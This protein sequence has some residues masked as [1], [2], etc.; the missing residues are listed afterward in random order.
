MAENSK[1][2]A[3]ALFSWNSTRIKGVYTLI[4]LDKI[5][6]NNLEILDAICIFMETMAEVKY[7]R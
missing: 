7:I 2:Q 6:I 4:Y 3:M 1:N 5:C